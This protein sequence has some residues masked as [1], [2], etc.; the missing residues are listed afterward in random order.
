M[1]EL[2]RTYGK[3]IH[4][5]APDMFPDLPLG[6][7]HLMMAYTSDPEISDGGGSVHPDPELLSARDS[8]YGTDTGASRSSRAQYLPEYTV[9]PG[10]D[11][12]MLLELRPVEA[13]VSK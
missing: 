4:T 6:P 5:W 13:T 2:Q 11:S 3:T 1:L 10:A 8:R 7:P 12:K 9:R